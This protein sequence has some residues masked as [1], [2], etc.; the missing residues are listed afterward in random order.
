MTCH[1]WTESCFGLGRIFWT[2][3][4]IFKSGNFY[5][6][7]QI[8]TKCTT[9]ITLTIL[10]MLKDNLIVLIRNFCNKI[11]IFVTD[12]DAFKRQNIV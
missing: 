11:E 8:L 12:R 4:K 6:L 5:P 3:K 1:L 7:N 9:H 10:I 2:E